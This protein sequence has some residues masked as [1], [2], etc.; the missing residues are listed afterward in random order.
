MTLTPLD[1][2]LFLGNFKASKNIFI[3]VFVE[4]SVQYFQFAPAM[5][6]NL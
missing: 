2:I 1:D 3:H 4:D 5:F 6:F